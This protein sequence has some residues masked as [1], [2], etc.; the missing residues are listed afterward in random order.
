MSK[1]KK[2]FRR[3]KETNSI[4]TVPSGGE[5]LHKQGLCAEIAE[6]ASF[7]LSGGCEDE[8]LWDLGVSSVEPHSGQSRFIIRVFPKCPMSFDELEIALEVLERARP[9]FRRE[10]ALAIHRK[11]APEVVFELVPPPEA[12][13]ET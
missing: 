11:R 3:S 1:G 6:I 10:I 7:L 9:F 4:Q 12:N 5:Q 2:P 8:R 13:H